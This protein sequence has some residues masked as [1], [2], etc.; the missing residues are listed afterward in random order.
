[1]EDK[2]AKAPIPP[3]P[4]VAATQAPGKPTGWNTKNYM[5]PVVRKTPLKV[6]GGVTKASQLQKIKEIEANIEQARQKAA[7]QGT[8]APSTSAPSEKYD[9]AVPNDYDEYVRQRSTRQRAEAEKRRREEQERR[10]EEEAKRREAENMA[11]AA[12]NPGQEKSQFAPPNPGQEQGGREGDNGSFA[13]RKM[14]EWGWKAGQGLGSQGQGITS[15]LEHQKTG[16]HTA[17]IVAPE[18]PAPPPEPPK[19]NKIKI[20]GRPTR[21]VMLRNMVG[22]GDV[23]SDLQPEIEEECTK[24][25]E[26]DRVAIFEV[27]DPKCPAEKAVRIF[28]KFVRQESAMKALVDLNGRFFGGRE[29]EAAFFSEQKFDEAKLAPEGEE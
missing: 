19:K 1:M 9:P 14:Q 25:G 8:L 20:R 18:A 22:P 4:P 13:Q 28:A 27:K 23:D 16:G 7:D 3:P 6:S 10:R 15:A 26:V 11:K 12:P 5:Q 2:T 29:V 21:V 17:V 24:Y